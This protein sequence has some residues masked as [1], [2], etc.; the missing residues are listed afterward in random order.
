MFEMRPGYNN[1]DP[2]VKGQELGTDFRGPVRANESG[3]IL[4]PLYQKLGEDGF[5]IGR[6][7][8][9]F[10]LK[11]SEILRALNVQDYVRYL[12]GVTHDPVEPETLIVNTRVARLFP[13]QIFHLLGFRKRRWINSNLVVSRRKHDSESP[14]RPR[15]R[16]R[17][18]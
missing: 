18:G 16:N 13:L 2:I 4:M 8:S 11:V 9:R 10:W 3:V 15:G 12:P 7:I 6:E 5:F 17:N 14:F 1:F